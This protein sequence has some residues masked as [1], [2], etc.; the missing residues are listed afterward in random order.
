MRGASSRVLATRLTGW[1]QT[2]PRPSGAVHLEVLAVMHKSGAL[3][4]ADTIV[5]LV[6]QPKP[7]RCAARGS[8]PKAAPPELRICRNGL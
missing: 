8:S 1:S 6:A 3:D 5:Q 4:N 7:G 2:R